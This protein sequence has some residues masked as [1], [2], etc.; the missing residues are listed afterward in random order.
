V[1]GLQGFFCIVE[2][3]RHQSLPEVMRALQSFMI[4]LIF[5]GQDFVCRAPEGRGAALEQ[6]LQM[7]ERRI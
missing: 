7:I 3:A 1:F 6:M 4:F 2:D 5:E